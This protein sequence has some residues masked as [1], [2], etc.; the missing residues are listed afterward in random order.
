MILPVITS[1]FILRFQFC[2][3]HVSSSPSR[4]GAAVSS[5]WSA[6]TKYPHLFLLVERLLLV[7]TIQWQEGCVSQLGLLHLEKLCLL[8]RHFFPNLL[9]LLEKWHR[10]VWEQEKKIHSQAVYW[11][12]LLLCGVWPSLVWVVQLVVRSECLL[13]LCPCL[14][15]FPS[16]SFQSDCVFFPTYYLWNSQASVLNQM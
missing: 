14:L 2:L 6:S 12:T 1:I 8:R 16:H 13:G 11:E 5:F 10:W 7:M 3:I 4:Y 15:R 9:W